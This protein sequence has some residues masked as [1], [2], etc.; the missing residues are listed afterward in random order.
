MSKQWCERR[1]RR[2]I[3]E[4]K[5]WAYWWWYVV[6]ALCADVI[7]VGQ[8]GHVDTRYLSVE[9][10]RWVVRESDGVRVKLACV[11]W[12]AHLEPMV[13]EGLDKQPLARLALAIRG[14]GFNCVRLTWA[15][16]MLTR[17][18]ARNTTVSERFKALNLSRALRGIHIH[19]PALVNL[20]LPDAFKAAVASMARAGMYVIADNHVSQ[21][22]WCCSANNDD[23]E[24][25]WGEPGFAVQEWLDGLRAMALHVPNLAG[26]SLR[27]ELRGPTQNPSDWHRFM[28]MGASVVSTANPHLLIF[29][30]GLNNDTDLHFLSSSSKGQHLSINVST[31][32]PKLVYEM[33]WYASSYGVNFAQGNLNQVCAIATSTITASG[34]FMASSPSPSPSSPNT[35]SSSF[36]AP[37]FI[38]EFGIDQRGGNKA[39]NRYI[40]CLFAFMASLDLDWSY[41]ALQGSYYRR[42]GNE[43]DEEYMGI[44]NAQWNAPRNMTFLA[45]LQAMQQP[46]KGMYEYLNLSIR[47]Y[48]ST[49][50]R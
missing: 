48:Y 12:A 50:L 19:N 27:N 24:G 3:M 43:G 1:R 11:N 31:A 8:C 18:G 5:S 21:A 35:S 46:W 38:S 29:V 2:R 41:W 44:L 36:V 17:G 16:H 30:A 25:F 9:S 26:I 4:C 42:Y 40:N 39:S 15:T 22:Q 10:S 34:A 49:Y 37:L 13:A 6:V 28:S 32:Q 20:T 33:H 45:K 7:V 14:M 47:L 23:V